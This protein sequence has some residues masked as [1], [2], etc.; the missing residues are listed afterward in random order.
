V[1]N[2]QDHIADRLSTMEGSRHSNEGKRQY[3]VTY[4][5]ARRR[6]ESGESLGLIWKALYRRPRGNRRGRSEESYLRELGL[7]SM[8]ADALNDFFEGRPPAYSMTQSTELRADL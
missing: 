4:V 7:S 3:A 8:R 1:S 5:A 2:R 6:C